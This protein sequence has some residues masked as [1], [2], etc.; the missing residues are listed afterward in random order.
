M[1]RTIA[2]LMVGVALVASLSIGLVLTTGSGGGDAV[3]VDVNSATPGAT[4]APASSSVALVDDGDRPGVGITVR[5]AWKIDVREPDGTLVQHVEF[6]NDLT[7]NGEALLSEILTRSR[8]VGWWIVRISGSVLPC[9]GSS[10]LIAEPAVETLPGSLTIDSYDLSVAVDSSG[11]GIRL[12]GSVVPE[13][14][15]DLFSVGTQMTPC[16]P[17][18]NIAFCPSLAPGALDVLTSIQLTSADTVSVEAGQIVQVD[19]L[20]TFETAP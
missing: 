11:R 19:I 3:V 7:A 9:G 14:A 17:E 13:L 12:R 4:V 16:T 20:L 8:D 1:N 10:C 2:T 15:S 6:H 18:S 5:G